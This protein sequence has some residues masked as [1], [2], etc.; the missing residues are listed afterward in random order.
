MIEARQFLPGIPLRIETE[1]G[2]V[3]LSLAMQRAFLPLLTPKGQKPGGM[4]QKAVMW[5]L[6]ED[7]I[8]TAA[9][10]FNRAGKHLDIL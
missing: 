10:A 7:D 3:Q 8:R 2:P 9:R 4:Q 1:Y 6:L 5:E